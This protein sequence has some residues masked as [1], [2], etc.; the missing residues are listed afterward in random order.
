MDRTRRPSGDPYEYREL[1]IPLS[2]RLEG[3]RRPTRRELADFHGYDGLVVRHLTI[4]A[5]D[6]W[7]ADE[8]ADWDSLAAGGRFVT[9]PEPAPDNP[10]E[11]ATVYRAVKIRLKRLTRRPGPGEGGRTEPRP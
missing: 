9:E 11:G 5:R 10:D 2:L 4:A 3:S 6:G 8:P 7:Q 1:V